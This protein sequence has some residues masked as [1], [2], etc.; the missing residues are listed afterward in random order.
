[1]KPVIGITLDWQEK[2]SFS[3][4]PHHALRTHYFE[5]V[6]AADGLPLGIPYQKELIGEYVE[7]CDG[8]LSPGGECAS[9]AEWYVDEEQKNGKGG[10]P[11]APSPRVAFELELTMAFLQS[12]KPVLGI[13][14]GMQQLGGLHGCRMT[15]DVH[16]YLKTELNHAPGVV[17]PEEYAY[18]VRIEKGTQLYDIIGKETLPVNTAHRE[19]LVTAGPDVVLSAHAPDG[20]I[21]A[22]ELAEYN[23]ALGI[24]WHPE[25]FTDAKEKGHR[26]IFESLVAAAV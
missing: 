1:M 22:I 23:F 16:S 10:S 11:Y 19:A 3:Q 15:G 25:Y 24:Q 5:A 7:R 17:P 14:Q 13:C 26:R 20:C 8:F 4:R 21:Q 12:G 2:G 6:A 9:P 18:E